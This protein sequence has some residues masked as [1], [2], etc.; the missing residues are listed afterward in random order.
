MSW[1]K[2]LSAEVGGHGVDR[3]TGTTDVD[4]A[5]ASG[6]EA[7]IEALALRGF[8]DLDR[9]RLLADAAVAAHRVHDEAVDVAEPGCESDA[10]AC[11]Q[12]A[13]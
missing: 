4:A 5:L 2:G 6:H 9:A 11:R 10:A 12:Q 8:R 7:S 3:D 1:A 13:T